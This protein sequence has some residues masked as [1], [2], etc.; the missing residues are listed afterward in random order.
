MIYGIFSD[1]HSNLE[2][3]EIV[4]NFYKKEKIEHFIFL[5]DIVGY[6]AN[7]KE[8]ISLLKKI[9]SIYIAGNHDWATIDKLDLRYFNIYA[10]EAIV[11]TKSILEEEDLLF[12]N[13]FSLVYEGEN[14]YCVHSSLDIPSQFKYISEPNEAW[15]NFS[16]MKKEILFIGHTHR[17]EIYH[18][19]NDTL[20]YYNINTILKNKEAKFFLKEG[21]YIVNVGSVG[22]PRDGDHRASLCIYDSVEK[23]LTF[24][25]LEYNIKKASE[26]ILKKGLPK[27]LAS[28]LYFGY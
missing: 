1:V 18:L 11:W 14:F 22:Q 25:R 7:P 20:Y 5:G 10:K 24:K 27:V 12:L 9:N 6:G 21:K 26:K 28:R 17:T 23:M 8:V 16:L 3:F 4:L 2:A 15:S 13:T 19:D